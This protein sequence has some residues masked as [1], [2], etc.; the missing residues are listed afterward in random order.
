M[1]HS[2]WP[3]VAGVRL[4]KEH[5]T[6]GD[7]AQDIFEILQHHWDSPFPIPEVPV[8]GYSRS[9]GELA[10]AGTWGRPAD[11]PFSRPPALFGRIRVDALVR[12][13]MNVH[14]T[15]LNDEYLDLGTPISEAQAVPS[16][17]D[18]SACR[19]LLGVR[20]AN[21]RS[22]LLVALIDRGTLSP[23]AS[24]NDL[25]GRVKH[26]NSTDVV[27]SRHAAE[28]FQT[29]LSRLVHHGLIHDVDFIAALV[30]PPAK[31]I[32]RSSFQHANVVELHDAVTR[33]A[34]HM[35]GLPNPTPLVANIS[36]GTHVGPHLGSTPLEL[37]IAKELPFSN[38]CVFVCSAGNDGL[39]NV[40]AHMHLD[41]GVEDHLRLRTSPA[42]C[43]EVLIELW[44]SEPS[45]GG[46]LQ[47]TVVVRDPQGARSTLPIKVDGQIAG[48]TLKT[49]G[50]GFKGVLCQSLYHAQ[51]L[52]QMHCLAIAFST[53][54]SSDLADL[55]I[56]ISLTIGH[57]AEV[58]A[59][60][61]LPQASVCGFVGAQA[62][63]SVTMPSTFTDA[64]SVA[65]MDNGQPWK[66][67][68]RG[69]PVTFG[70]PNISHRGD[71]PGQWLKGTSFAA[72]RVTADL[73]ERFLRSAATTQ[74]P[75]AVA[76]F[77]DISALTHDVLSRH[78]S[79]SR[80]NPRT[81]NGKI[82]AGP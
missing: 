81:G 3:D 67:S 24:P 72:P 31:S 37:D 77:Q 27:F 66:E 82:L 57:D 38:D 7:I 65:A 25:G 75:L 59:W 21:T 58:N 52:G 47:A 2:L 34:S 40:S 55:T 33:L 18:L 30:H 39:S 1:L 15:N 32:G 50:A 80:W 54:S 45:G 68:S 43:G 70:K 12:H 76:H 56:D 46:T 28:V 10:R 35:K 22:R 23:G 78:G 26:L 6:P 5:G 49:A 42:G 20:P 48:S 17:A 62:A 71:S 60:V 9:P 29:L 4:L 19:Q 79:H 63:T 69:G 61:V 8:S 74:F 53:S 13:L 73:V 64:L 51:C 14:A 11:A 16:E 44:W 36:M 41:A